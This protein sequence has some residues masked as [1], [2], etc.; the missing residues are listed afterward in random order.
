MG[1]SLGVF[2]DVVVAAAAVLT[3]VLLL[4]IWVRAVLRAR[5]PQITI[6]DL[7]NRTGREDLDAV[8]VAWSADVR[9]RLSEA[10]GEV[11][12]RLRDYIRQTEST[13]AEKGF[14]LDLPRQPGMSDSVRARQNERLRTLSSSLQATTRP[15]AVPVQAITELITTQRGTTVTATLHGRPR[16]GGQHLGITVEI[17]DL[18]GTLSERHTFWQLDEAQGGGIEELIRAVTLWIA[19]EFTGGSLVQARPRRLWLR[20]KRYQGLVDNLLGLVY[21]AARHYAGREEEFLHLAVAKFKASI[22]ALPDEYQPRM[23]LGLAY[24]DLAF[25]REDRD[26]Q[27]R[28]LDRAITEY[29]KSINV[30]KTGKKFSSRKDAPVLVHRLEEARTLAQLYSPR[31]EIR[32]RALRWLREESERIES[33]PLRLQRYDYRLEP[34]IVYNA[35]CMWAIASAALGEE[36]WRDRARKLLGVALV[37]D[38][39]SYLWD[40]AT[41]DSDLS[42]LGSG[43]ERTVFEQRLRRALAAHGAE[44]PAINVSI[45]EF[46]KI[47]DE[48]MVPEPQPRAAP[49]SE[50][51]SAASAEAPPRT[52][53]AVT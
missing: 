40:Q 1:D 49:P 33:D 22:A 53:R 10:L 16:G 47:V 11:R 42:A 5:Q 32:D 7:E 2:V 9:W 24:V 45:G 31:P 48:A 17:A 51:G 44:D 38:P 3:I 13:E 52:S 25:C 4:F 34:Y 36:A 39:E 43:E 20:R 12:E 29:K 8:R 50:D 15:L 18:S 14:D 30:V 19:V 37:K 28:Y 41:T 21:Q 27:E 6:E 26:W 35:A 23:N 46:E